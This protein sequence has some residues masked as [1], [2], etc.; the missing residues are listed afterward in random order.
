MNTVIRW[1]F[2][3]TMAAVLTACGGS[4]G[5]DTE[6]DGS[7]S[8][9]S[10]SSSDD[11]GSSSSS[12]SSA[13]TAQVGVF[14]DSPVAGIG[15]RTSPGGREGVTNAEG[16][17]LFDEN[18]QVIFFIGDLELPPVRA[19]GVVT[20]LDIA[21]TDDLNN[22]VVVN[23]A[24][25][26]QSLDADGDP[27]NG[28]TILPEAAAVAVAVNFNQS[29]EDFATSD[30]VI[31]L[32]ANSGSSTNA[33]VS[34]E[35]ARAH[36]QASMGEQVRSLIGSWYFQDV[37]DPDLDRQRHVV[38][39]F[40]DSERFVLI[41][42]NDESNDDSGQ[43]GFEYGHYTWNLRTGVAGFS[44]I[45]DTNGK[46]GTSHP[47]HESEVIVLEPRGDILYLHAEGGAGAN[48]DDV[49]D[50]EAPRLLFHRVYSETNPLVGSWVIDEPE[51]NMLAVVVF[52]EDGHYLMM[53]EQPAN[54]DGTSGIERGTYTYDRQS[55]EVTFT[56]HTDT[57]GTRGFSNPCAAWD[58]EGTN[59]LAC[60]P[61]G[62][63]VV[64]TMTVQGS[65]LT[66]SEADTINNDREVQP[67]ELI[68]IGGA[69]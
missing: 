64:Q 19:K 6:P 13:P 40:L 28:I 18:D 22:P 61:G 26:L 9:S 49:V 10:Q 59:N 12:S 29:V 57:N 68:R 67:V 32:V 14:V 45:V 53:D 41:T 21:D 44:P 58:V 36:L 63:N 62:A 16:E 46:W 1:G 39:T 8:S 27:S 17:Y 5:N 4:G 54:D 51:E 37:T 43:D 35:A 66:Y 15:Y 20:P 7:A 23:I 47:C 25:L 42:D 3:V 2:W 50:G 33:L 38:F 69:L 55:R 30:A 60:G 24:R 34:A 31:N 48:C 56:T 65:V 11:S 52:A